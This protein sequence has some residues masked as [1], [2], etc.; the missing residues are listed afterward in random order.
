MYFDKQNYFQGSHSYGVGT[1][2]ES[3]ICESVCLSDN[4]EQLD[5]EFIMSI[6][7]AQSFYTWNKLNNFHV[8][9]YIL[10]TKLHG[11]DNS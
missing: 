4:Y 9:C 11:Q 7:H 6:E 2:R 5:T 8:K 10:F 3:R 1:F